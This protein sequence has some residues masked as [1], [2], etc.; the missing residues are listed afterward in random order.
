[1]IKEEKLEIAKW[2]DTM[3]YRLDIYSDDFEL[4]L[5]CIVDMLDK[6]DPEILPTLLSEYRN[7]LGLKNKAITALRRYEFIYIARMWD[8]ID[9]FTN[10]WGEAADLDTLYNL[11]DDYNS[12]YYRWMENE[13]RG[14]KGREIPSALRIHSRIKIRNFGI[15]DRVP[16]NWWYAG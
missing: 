8:N 15:D 5:D 10:E 9:C 4:E 6:E 16:E 3:G 11:L 1:M 14:D 7:T 13:M 12:P 2:L